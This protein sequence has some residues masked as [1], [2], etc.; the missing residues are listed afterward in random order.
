MREK[1]EILE[2]IQRM[3]NHYPT[4]VI[5]SKQNGVLSIEPATNV[6]GV[7]AKEPPILV[8][9]VI[10]GKWMEDI[11]GYKCSVCNY[12]IFYCIIGKIYK[13][14]NISYFRKPTVFIFMNI[15]IIYC[16]GSFRRIK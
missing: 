8:K 7:G 14:R 12:V 9:P 10:K 15:F 11:S 6:I 13:L 16:Y 2:K 3:I 4:W 1:E 5:A